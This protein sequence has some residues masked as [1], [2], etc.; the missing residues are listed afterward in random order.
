MVSTTTNDPGLG[1]SLVLFDGD[2]V[3]A[4]ILEPD[5]LKSAVALAV[6]TFSLACL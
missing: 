6:Y 3:L 1:S 2:G 4:D 5:E